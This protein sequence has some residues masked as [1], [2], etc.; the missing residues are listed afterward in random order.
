MSD[1]RTMSKVRNLLA[2]AENAGTAAEADRARER[3]EALMLKYAIDEAILAEQQGSTDTIDTRSVQLAAPYAKEK[4]LTLTAVAKHYQVRVIS[5]PTNRQ[6]RDGL[7]CTMVGFTADLDT[8][9]MLVTSL[10]LQASRD[11]MRQQPPERLT[12]RGF[13][14][15]DAGAFRRSWLVGF[16]GAVA[17][18]LS[19]IR[20][21]TQTQVDA[22]RSGRGT[23]LVLRDRSA[24][25]D[26]KVTELF[27]R[28]DDARARRYSG[29]GAAGGYAAGKRADLGQ[30]KV[31]TTKHTL[32]R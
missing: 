30:T 15:E 13:V 1:E 4:A 28:L 10:L 24:Q 6:G 32:T 27:P 19:R 21:R 17:D 22:E 31:A 3:A 2:L 18:R 12:V 23:E 8:V 26:D 11:V 14:R 25:V 20:E 9:D 29:S 5:H 7:R 16:A